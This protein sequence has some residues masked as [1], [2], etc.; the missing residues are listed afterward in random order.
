MLLLVNLI[1]AAGSSKGATAGDAASASAGTTD[2]AAN[3][4]RRLTKDDLDM[5][6]RARQ[7]HAV[8]VYTNAGEKWLPTLRALS[9]PV[10][11][12]SQL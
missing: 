7:E 3:D 6:F 10:P 4:A 2:L 8:P 1:E 12:R 11:K 5:L 9:R